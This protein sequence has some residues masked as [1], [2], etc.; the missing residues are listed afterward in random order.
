MGNGE[1]TM[2]GK[3]TCREAEVMKWLAKGKTVSI[4]AQILGISAKTAESHRSH[5]YAKLDITSK[6]QLVEMAIRMG[7]IPMPEA[8][9]VDNEDAL[10]SRFDASNRTHGIKGKVIQIDRDAWN[11]LQEQ[12][13]FDKEARRATA[14][15][16]RYFALDPGAAVE[17]GNAMLEERL[18]LGFGEDDA[19]VALMM[20]LLF[21]AEQK[22]GWIANA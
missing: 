13:A 14:S 22:L 3:I 5:L 19:A 6:A 1:K 7:I 12:V 18:A 4:T 21:Q 2:N 20:D 10:R 8:S 17:M 16:W 15:F 9:I 11:K